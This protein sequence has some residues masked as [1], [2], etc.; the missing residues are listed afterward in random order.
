ML[1]ECPECGRYLESDPLAMDDW[2]GEEVACGPEC[3][4][5]DQ[6]MDFVES[7]TVSPTG[8]KP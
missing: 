1:W 8:E 2:G 5:C 4:E 6:A 7:L 3:Q